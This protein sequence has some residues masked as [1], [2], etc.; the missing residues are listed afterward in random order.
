MKDERKKRN[1]REEKWQK[2]EI[3]MKMKKYIEI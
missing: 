1:W 3:N 2:K